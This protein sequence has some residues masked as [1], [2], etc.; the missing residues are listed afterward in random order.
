MIYRVWGLVKYGFVQLNRAG[1]S[2][3]DAFTCH[4]YQIL[5]Y[6]DQEQVAVFPNGHF[7]R[8]LAG[9][10]MWKVVKAAKTRTQIGI[11][12]MVNSVIV[13]SVIGDRLESVPWQG[14]T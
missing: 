8:R 1:R 14:S 11:Q 10:W 6:F 13:T 4:I 12:R 2:V 5:E 3:Y 7:L 9:L